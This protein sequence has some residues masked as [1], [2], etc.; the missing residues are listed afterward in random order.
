MPDIYEKILIKQRINYLKF[1]N[2][3]IFDKNNVEVV[4]KIYKL[5]LPKP[6][7]L[8]LDIFDNCYVGDNLFKAPNEYSE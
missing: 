7:Q 4:D 8:K 2:Y 5:E 3:K 6:I 1:K